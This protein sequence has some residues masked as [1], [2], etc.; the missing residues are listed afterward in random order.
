MNAI[1][2]VDALWPVWVLSVRLNIHTDTDIACRFVFEWKI[3]IA[4]CWTTTTNG[5]TEIFHSTN[6]PVPRTYIYHVICPQSASGN[7]THTRY[8]ERTTHAKR[9]Q[10]TVLDMIL[11]LDGYPDPDNHYISIRAHRKTKLQIFNF[12]LSGRSHR[13]IKYSFDN[14]N[15][16]NAHWANRIST[17]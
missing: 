1:W 14:K 12:G 5:E 8:R 10:I 11:A 6:R 16:E 4:G 3:V 2:N 13:K 17:L 7:G 15:V 9:T